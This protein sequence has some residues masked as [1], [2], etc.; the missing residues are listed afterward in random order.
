[1]GVF[2]DPIEENSCQD[3]AWYREECN[4]PV[5]VT[6]LDVTFPLPDRNVKAPSAIGRDDPRVPN[7]TQQSV[8]PQKDGG[9]RADFPGQVESQLT[10]YGSLLSRKLNGLAPSLSLL[11]A[12]TPSRSSVRCCPVLH[13]SL[14]LRDSST[15]F[16][17]SLIRKVLDVPGVSRR[18]LSDTFRLWS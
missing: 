4:L 13:S 10:T 5:V 14:A 3:L 7:G 1:M 17:V 12:R 8:Q 11:T 2:G 16:R 18:Q 15:M 6:L 9:S